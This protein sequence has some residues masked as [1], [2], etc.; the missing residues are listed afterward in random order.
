[1]EGLK[2]ILEATERERVRSLVEADMPTADRLHDDDFELINPLGA[3]L[4]KEQYLGGI[5]SGDLD[6]QH[7][8]P[9]EI[10]IRIYSNGAALR[11]ES[12]LEIIVFGQLSPSAKYLH[13]DVYEERS[14]FW[15]VIWSQ[16]TLI[17]DK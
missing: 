14:G 4:S 16:A 17:A 1:M 2:D 9:G 12:D 8:I 3:R 15:Q 7:W 6:Y 13:T 11:Y 5:A 10:K